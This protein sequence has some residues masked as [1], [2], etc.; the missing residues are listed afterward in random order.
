M[1]FKKVEVYFL[2]VL[3]VVG[4]V[5]FYMSTITKVTMPEP[6]TARAYGMVISGL[7]LLAVITRFLAL[8][9]KG[10]E[11]DGKKFSIGHPMLIVV[12]AIAI[13]LYTLG[14]IKVG[15]Y[16]MTFLFMFGMVMIL[17]EKRSVKQWI[18]T[19]VGCLIFT[20]ALY[21]VFDAFN[22][23]LPNAWLI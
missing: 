22:V 14:I 13:V 10:G 4:G 9:G 1:S 19:A 12:S 2:L 21:F 11:D 17:R 16:V 18:L 20:V 8:V 3:I 6:V 15:Y 23:Y 5:M 7:F